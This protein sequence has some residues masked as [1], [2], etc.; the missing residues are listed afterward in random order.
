LFSELLP[1]IARTCWSRSKGTVFTASADPVAK[2]DTP[3][4]QIAA[5]DT[6]NEGLNFIHTHSHELNM[7]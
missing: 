2:F 5:F 1:D 4:S 6:Q 7:A 3:L